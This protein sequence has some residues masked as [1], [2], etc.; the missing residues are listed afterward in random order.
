MAS[1]P[2]LP[3]LAIIALVLVVGSLV[4]RVVADGW[5]RAR[6]TEYFHRHGNTVQAI[7]WQ[8][9]AQWWVKGGDRTYL[10]DYLMA[11]GRV[12]QVSCRTSLSG[13][14]HVSED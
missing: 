3:W 11:D 10:V 13:G 12:R 6:I 5:D 8:P 7:T 1:R 2:W 14:V 4:A 9:F